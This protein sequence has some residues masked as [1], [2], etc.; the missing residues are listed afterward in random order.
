MLNTFCY[1][2]EKNPALIFLHGLFGEALD[3]SD[4]ISLLKDDF[5][6]IGL[7]L[8]GHGL[9]P[10]CSPLS[11]ASVLE[12]LFSTLAKL[13]LIQPSLVGYS[14]GGRLAMLLYKKRPLF[15]H[16]AI[17]L[18]AHPGLAPK[19]K[20]KRKKQ[21]EAWLT[22]LQQNS[23]KTFLQLWYNAPLFNALNATPLITRRSLGNKEAFLATMQNLRLSK[24]PSLWPFIHATQKSWLFLSG[25][26]D[27]AYTRLY[28][29]LPCQKAIIPYV[30][31]ALPLE[32]PE[33]TAFWI[34]TFLVP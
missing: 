26:K 32:A 20:L 11:F 5:F 9:S 19:E 4:M 18:S 34:K 25:E 12:V 33:L 3:F 2:H 8:P 14:L 21:E 16:K 28:E 17:I 10:L 23:L 24:Q 27:L 15:F 30:S 1:G 22:L 6:C 29:K 13:P 7:D 31:H